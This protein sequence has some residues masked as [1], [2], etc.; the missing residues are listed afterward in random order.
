MEP[1]R[2]HACIHNFSNS[3]LAH[4]A[5]L[6]DGSKF[7]SCVHVCCGQIILHLYNAFLPPS[8]FNM[9]VPFIDGVGGPVDR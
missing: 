8:F 2:N 5:S 3:H 7:L 9:S 1:G 6:V 4:M